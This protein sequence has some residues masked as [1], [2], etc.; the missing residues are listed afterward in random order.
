MLE[1]LEGK[2]GNPRIK[3]PFPTV[4]LLIALP[5]N[6]V[7]TIADV[8]PIVNREGGEAYSKIGVGKSTELN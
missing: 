8:V 6:N 4:G 3:P 7:E 1:S 2:R 5:L